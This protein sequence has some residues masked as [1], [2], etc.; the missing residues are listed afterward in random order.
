M[1]HSFGDKRGRADVRTVIHRS[2]NGA[3]PL[4]GDPFRFSQVGTGSQIGPGVTIRGPVIIAENCLLEDCAIGPHV[5]IGAGTEIR[6]AKIEH[7]IILDNCEIDA[8]MYL[9]DSLIGK[10]ARLV[11]KPELDSGRQM[12][13]FK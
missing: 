13:M 7:S 1:P 4:F 5:T 12:I 2:D 9:K 6:R 3:S 10:K 11:R 8:D